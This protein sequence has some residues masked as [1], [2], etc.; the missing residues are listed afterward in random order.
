MKKSL[1]TLVLFTNLVYSTSYEDAKSIEKLS[2]LKKAYP[3]YE[4]LIKESNTKAMIRMAKFHIKSRSYSK[5]IKL[6]EE[7]IYLE[8]KEAMYILGRFYLSKKTIYHNNIKA[9][10]LFV[11]ASK[12]KHSK[13]QMM[14]GKFFLFGIGI[15]KDYELALE[16][17]KRASKQKVYASNCYIS[18][19]YAAGFGVFPNFGR[20]HVFAKDQYKKGNKLCIKV[21]KDYNLSKYPKDNSWKIGEY[22]SPIK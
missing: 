19:M 11:D 3:L 7:A 22:N 20:A 10:N 1:L 18:Y 5:A 8:D 17:F 14:L 16:Y 12:Q 4:E 6:L 13:A 2:G 9:Y 15:D 21:W